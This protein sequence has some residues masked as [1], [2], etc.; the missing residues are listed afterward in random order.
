MA[1]SNPFLNFGGEIYKTKP[2]LPNNLSHLLA[3]WP[4]FMNIN[5]ANE[6]VVVI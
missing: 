5:S 6:I 1:T 2:A 3:Y 4:F